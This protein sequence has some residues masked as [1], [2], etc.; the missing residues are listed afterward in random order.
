[1]KGDL[2]NHTYLSDGRES[3]AYVIAML[4]KKGADFASITD[5]G[6]YQPSLEA[7]EYWKE[8]GTDF[9]VLPGEEVH[10]PDCRVHILSV[11]GRF[12]VNSWGYD[13]AS[14]YREKLEQEKS[15]L[16]ANLDEDDRTRIAASQA[17]FDKAR[18]AGALSLFCHPFW[19]TADGFDI[20]EDVTRYLLDHRRFDA[21][22]VIGGY[23]PHE[24]RDNLFQTAYYYQYCMG[25]GEPPAAYGMLRLPQHRLR[26]VYRPLLLHCVCRGSTPSRRLRERYVPAA[27]WP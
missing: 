24:Y 2:H 25:A 1:M 4:R 13:G 11:G 9:L 3:P 23:W 22:E 19:E 7:L 15:K 14:D 27:A 12:S 17:V 5:H 21:L 6:W 20:H 26:A 18:E 10:A 8:L 16:P